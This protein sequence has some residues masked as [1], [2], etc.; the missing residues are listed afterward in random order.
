MPDRPFLSRFTPSRTDP[1][2]LEAIFVQRHELA[3][4]TVERIHESAVSGNKHHLLF[5]GPRGS[6]KTHLVSLIFRRVAL[7]EDLHERLR[8]AWLGEDETTTSF[9]DLLLRIYRAL[10]QRYANEFPAEALEALYQLSAAAAAKRLG[11]QLLEKLA[12]RT[13]LVIVENVDALFAGL[14]AAG[15]KQWRAFI[16]EN[17]VF[18]TLA[19]SQQLFDGVS[20]RD[21]AF[22]GFFRTEHLRPLT[23]EEAVL[24]LRKIAELSEE[25][26]DKNLAGF[27][28]TPAGRARVRALHHLSGGNHRIYIVL[29]EFVTRETLDE[30]IGPFEKMIDELTPYYQARVK[31]L[32]PQQRKLVEFLC[33]YRQPVP[34]TQIARSLFMT[35]QTATSQLKG[36]REKG[37]VQSQPRGRES[38]YELTEPLMRICVEV[39][40]NWREPIRLIV[41]FLRIWYTPEQLRT[42]PARSS[43]EQ[44]YVHSAREAIDRGE[45][46]LRVRSIIF[47]LDDQRQRGQPK[48]RIRMLEELSETRGDVDDWVE[49]ADALQKE[50]R[51]AESL[52]A[53]NEALERDPKNPSAWLLMG[54]ALGSTGRHEEELAAFGKALEFDPKRV[55]A[56][57]NRGIALGKLGRYEEALA[58][59]EQA[60]TLDPESVRA[61]VNRGDALRKLGKHA[62]ALAA[63]EQACTLDPKSAH[64]W[65]NRGITLE[66]LGRYAEALAAYEQ[67]CTLDPKS[68]R[69]W[70]NR[71]DTLRKLGKHTE[72]LAAYEQAC[73][74]DPKSAFAWTNRGD[75]LR[76]L[77]KHAEALAAYEQ[78]CTLDPKSAFAWTNRGDALRRL[79]KHAEALAAYEQACTLDPKSAF[80][81]N[82]RGMALENLERYAEALAAY[83]QACALDPKSAHAWNN[84]GITLE[85][86]GRYA[87]ALAAF[88]Q[89]CALDPKS[90]AAWD[91][92]G[93]ALREAGRD[94]EALGAYE[95]AL[96]L[97]PRSIAAWNGRG[98]ALQNLGRYAEA[99]AAYD[100]ALQ[101][102]PKFV[103]AWNNRGNALHALRQHT[104]ALAAYDRALEL[105]PRHA[106]AWHGRGITLESLGRYA[107]ALAACNEALELDSKLAYAWASR[108]LALSRLGRNTEA[109]VAYDKALELDP[110][111]ATGWNNRSVVLAEL[112]RYEEALASCERA[113]DLDP[114][115]LIPSYSRVEALLLSD[116][117][118]A[119]FVALQQSLKEF[120]PSLKGYAGD[121]KALVKIMMTGSLE[122]ATWQQRA[123]RLVAIYAEAQALTYLGEGLVRSLASLAANMLSA[124][125]LVAWRDVWHEAGAGHDQLIIPLRIFD[126]GIRYLQT[127]DRRV[128]LDLL[129]EE[130]KILAEALSID[131]EGESA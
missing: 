46:D 78:A 71:G 53:C 61:W 85:N 131:L 117:W 21:S 114:T 54:V 17:A 22:F 112:G 57:I 31:G 4:D 32:S 58:A 62:E 72:A 44:L 68:A 66:H 10:Q 3:N 36:L 103:H 95:Q 70:V 113:H 122:K 130:R 6:G 49:F 84:R 41:D 99:L 14:K 52:A 93:N 129:T 123:S 87:E 2:I 98:I 108:G 23:V 83:E 51:H 100:Q 19:T 91:N 79:G 127:K 125:A 124:E 120:P 96:Q 25:S 45:E 63:Y 116:R 15:Q 65:N 128:L 50:G 126:A 48:E 89:A 107:E 5:I 67:A 29:S 8:I 11:K 69:A 56:W 82:W 33:G 105:D 20:R 35:H 74:L 30:L 121:T 115:D 27:L 13:L 7:S 101:L 1:D 37:Y 86:L 119:G 59:Y 92:R 94:A 18:T 40:E 109:L 77:G 81:W 28:Q 75:A 90:V 39:K 47:D 34:V 111:D 38:L 12:G 118:E 43:L 73:T 64:A 110:M 42:L 104:E 60:C 97:D 102:D 24:L 9:L 80:A 76:K 16:Q 55:I 88:E 106:Y 26:E